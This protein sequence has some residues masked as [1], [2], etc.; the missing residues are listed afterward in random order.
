MNA[1]GMTIPNVA[2][3]WAAVAK[4]FELCGLEPGSRQ[5]NSMTPRDSAL[6]HSD[7]VPYVNQSVLLSI[8]YLL[9]NDRIHG[10][11]QTIENTGQVGQQAHHGK[12]S[13]R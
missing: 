1:M 10:G 8:V 2:S 12:G 4:S 9:P 13:R 6:K 7:L 5:R 3:L 11:E